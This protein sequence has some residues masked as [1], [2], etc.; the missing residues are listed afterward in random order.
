VFFF[1][2]SHDGSSDAPGQEVLRHRTLLRS[3]ML[4]KHALGYDVKSLPPAKRLRANLADLATSNLI[5]GQR[6]QELYNDADAAG[7]ANVRDMT[8]S[9]GKNARRNILRKLLKG[10]KWPK[11]YTAKIRVRNPK[12]EEVVEAPMD[13]LLVHEVVDKLFKYNDRSKLLET[14]G[15]EPRTKTHLDNVAVEL[16]E[17]ELLGLGLWLDGCPCNWDRTKSLEVITMSLPGLTGRYKNL[18][19]PLVAMP[20]EFVACEDTFDDLLAIVAWSFQHLAMKRY[21]SKRHD[22]SDWSDSE[23]E[24]AAAAG[25]ELPVAAALVEVRGDWKMMKEVFRLPGWKEKAGCCWLCCAVPAD[26]RKN[27]AGAAWRRNRLTHWELLHRMLTQNKSI[28]PLF[29]CPGIKSHCFKIDWLHAADQGCTADFLGNALL[30]LLGK[31]PGRNKKKRLSELFQRICEFYERTGTEAR[32]QSLSLGMLKKQKGSPKLRCS[33]AEA[34]ALVPFIK[35]ACEKYLDRHDEE[36]LAVMQMAFHLDRL[37]GTLSEDSIFRAD[38]MREH[39]RKF[40]VLYTALEAKYIA[41]KLKLWRAK[42][43]MHLLQELC[44]ETEGAAP[45]R[46][47]CYRDEDFGGAAARLARRRG[48]KCTPKSVSKNM[49]D[50]YRAKHDFPRDIV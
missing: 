26:V 19:I 42:P 24:R 37:Y 17:A 41:L 18:R 4:S 50:N 46:S 22:G 40:C 3:R 16:G 27:D 30:T 38:L 11:S 13:M 36:E 12:T 6:A 49:L 45:S 33:A 47:W 48:G 14:A 43:K 29:S 34:R 2:H 44:E 28:S 10:S 8:G 39:C 25:R 7:A 23:K 21:P 1:Q 32:L 9:S 31:M 35:E 15:M 20:H 5:S